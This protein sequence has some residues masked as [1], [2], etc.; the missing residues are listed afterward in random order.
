MLSA[1]LLLSK[2]TVEVDR[3]DNAW[4]I[5]KTLR[6]NSWVVKCIEWDE[7]YNANRKGKTLRVMGVK[8]LRLQSE[9]T[10]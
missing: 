1:P 10:I 6:K 5:K 8:E 2:C 4:R 9:P 3:A 7:V